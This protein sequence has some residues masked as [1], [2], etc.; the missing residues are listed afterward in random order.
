M[1]RSVSLLLI[2]LVGVVAWVLARPSGGDDLKSL[3]PLTAFEQARAQQSPVF[4][5][6]TSDT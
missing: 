5:M 1:K 6:F 2:L 4:V 3:A